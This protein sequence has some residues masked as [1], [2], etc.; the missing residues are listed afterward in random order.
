MEIPDRGSGDLDIGRSL[1]PEARAVDQ[2]TH[3]GHRLH[4]Y[5]LKRHFL[6][7]YPLPVN[8]RTGIH[9]HDQGTRPAPSIE[10]WTHDRQP[11]EWGDPYA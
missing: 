7:R 11:G 2:R 8:H 9:R 4:I 3:K 1:C 10:C 6:L 5:R